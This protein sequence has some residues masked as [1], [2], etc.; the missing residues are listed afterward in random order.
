[1][2]IGIVMRAAQFAAEKHRHQRRKDAQASP[3]INHPIALANV[4]ANEAGITDPEVL[5]A[6]LLH[7]TIEDTDT[8]AEELRAAF[9]ETI[10][11]IVLEVTDDK[12]L[13]REERKRLQIVH[14]PQASHKAKLV[15]LADKICNLRDMISSPPARWSLERR[16]EYF[17]WAAQVVAG[18]RDAHPGLVAIFDEVHARCPQA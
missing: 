14:T 1:V 6:A 18:A 5:C 8:T 11:E 13:S 12:A 15:K 3:Y 10:A 7:D 16:Q 17:E 2:T 9:G 4:L